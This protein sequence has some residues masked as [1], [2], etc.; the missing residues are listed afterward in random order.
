MSKR[1]EIEDVSDDEGAAGSNRPAGDARG[2]I[3]SESAQEQAIDE[4]QMINEEYKIWKKN[5]P[6]LYD[7]VITHAL[8]WPTLTCQWFPDREV[9]SNK[10]F[11]NHRLLLGTHTSNQASDFVQIASLQL[12]RRDGLPGEENIGKDQYDE[13]KGE[14]VAPAGARTSP[15]SITQRINHDGEVNCARYMP[16]NPDIIATKTTT[17]DVWIFD[18][19]KHPNKPDKEGVFKPDIVLNGQTQEGFGL[20]WS[21]LK[22]GH[23][24]SSS[25]DTTVCHWDVQ[26]FT[27]LGSPLGPINTFQGHDSSVNH[28]SWNP[29][30][31]N[32]FASVADDG[33]LVIWDLRAGNRP[34][35]RYQA[36]GSAKGSRPEILSVAYSPSNEYLLLTGGGDQSIALHDMRS[37]AIETAASNTT[38]RLADKLHTFHA[39]TDEVMHVVWSPHVPSVFASGSADRRVNIWDISQIGQEQTPDDAEDGPPELLFVHGG[40]MARIADLGWAPNLEDKWT[41]VSAGEDNVVM[42]WSPTWRIWASEEARPKAGELERAARKGGAYASDEEEE[43]EDGDEE[44]SGEGEGEEGPGETDTE[45]GRSA[46]GG[47]PSDVEGSMRSSVAPSEAA[48]MRSAPK[49]TRDAMDE[50]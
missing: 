34:A 43:E 29:Y 37:T 18:R 4:N 44:M 20:A 15:F 3:P 47:A 14:L 31:E 48:S 35:H 33:L 30:Q 11:T 23:I 6:Y 40:H 46:A 27:T 8:D 1:M 10:S 5:A 17:G 50:D 42:I 45:T 26:Q 21:P 16:Q 49:S 28:V 32:I 36:H 9:V 25:T 24:I 2:D 19:T 7:V 12:P 38:V 41:L 13:E 39:H 22:K